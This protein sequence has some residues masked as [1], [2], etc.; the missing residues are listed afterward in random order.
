[1]KQIDKNNTNWKKKHG[2]YLHMDKKYH[3]PKSF[4]NNFVR[5]DIQVDQD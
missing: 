2:I 3:Q 5:L 1:M 4:E